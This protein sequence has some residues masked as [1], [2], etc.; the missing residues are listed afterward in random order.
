[1]FKYLVSILLLVSQVAALHFYLEGDQQRCFYE[2]LPKGTLVVGKYDAWEYQPESGQWIKPH[3]LAILTTIEETFDNDH[4]VRS[5]R[6]EMAGD[7]HYI[8]ADHG[9][10][11][12]CFRAA[13][14]DRGWFKNSRVKITFDM[15]FGEGSLLDS[16]NEVKV[17][18]IVARLQQVRQRVLEIRREQV[19]MR[20]R[21]AQF[22]DQ[23]ESTNSRVVRWIII[24]AIVLGATCAWQLNH[25]RG[26]FTKQKLV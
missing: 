6:G 18:G 2:E 8:T 26:F 9:E 12:I 20:E 15:S 22:R 13:T 19:Y 4:M 23:S 10:H 21:E 14:K 25:L 16:K 7:I 3:N 1:M 5:H 11:K 17:Q 24:Q